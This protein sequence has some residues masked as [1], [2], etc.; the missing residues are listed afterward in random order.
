MICP[1]VDLM[2]LGECYPSSPEQRDS[3]LRCLSDLNFIGVLGKDGEIC[4]DLVK[5]EK[6][7]TEDGMTPEVRLNPTQ[8]Q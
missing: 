4:R 5:V 6:N 1:L 2:Y 8:P 7:E 3:V